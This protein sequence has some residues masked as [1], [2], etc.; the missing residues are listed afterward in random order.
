M[1]KAPAG[2][3]GSAAR[4]F[5]RVEWQRCVAGIESPQRAGDDSR[6]DKFQSGE[7]AGDGSGVLSWKGSQPT[8]GVLERRVGYD[9]VFN[10]AASIVAVRCRV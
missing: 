5:E 4:A 9:A 3:S 2:G 10:A 6:F 1:C 8:V 7:E